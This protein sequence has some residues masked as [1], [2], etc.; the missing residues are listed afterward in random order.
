MAQ[1]SGIG[2]PT[3]FACAHQTARVAYRYPEYPI[4]SPSTRSTAARVLDRQPEYPIDHPIDQ[5]DPTDRSTDR[6]AAGL[7]V[8]RPIS[9]SISIANTVRVTTPAVGI[10]TDTTPRDIIAFT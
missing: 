2:D 1:L 6:P 10:S 9:F 7:V 8:C 3:H 4:D 5:P